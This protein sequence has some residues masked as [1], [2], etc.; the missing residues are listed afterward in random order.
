MAVWPMMIVYIWNYRLK[1][2]E[3]LGGYADNLRLTEAPTAAAPAA[4][5]PPSISGPSPHCLCLL[6]LLTWWR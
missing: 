3:I 6:P 1:P 5:S 2:G 4:L